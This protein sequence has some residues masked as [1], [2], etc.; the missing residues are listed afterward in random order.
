MPDVSVAI[1]GAGASGLSTAA[2]LKRRGIEAVALEQ[3]AE[4][5]LTWSRRYDRL[6][7]HTLRAYSGLAHYAIPRAASKY[8]SRDEYVDYLQSYARHFDLRIITNFAVQK[9]RA[10]SSSPGAWQVCG[11]QESWR[12]RVVVMATGQYRIP[13]IPAWP[14]LQD[15]RGDFSHAAKYKNPFPYV[16]KRVLVVGVGNTGA[17]IAADLVER[18]A[19]YVAISIRTPPTIVPR[20]P[21][22]NPVQRTSMLMS[23]L[24]TRIADR[25][26]KVTARIVLG[27]L[28][29]YGLPPAEWQ[30][31]TLGRVP[32][33]DVGFVG[34]LRRGLVTIRPAL[35]RLTAHEA[36]YADGRSEA[37]DAIIAA[38]GFTT[39]LDSLLEDTA[40]LND[41]REPKNAAG[42]PTASPGLFFI[43]FT[44]S[45][46]GHLFEANRASLKLARN[47]DQYMQRR[48]SIP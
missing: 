40:T 17:E 27:D 47:I 33:I 36:V 16:G 37:F 14:G 22:G 45:L 19:A 44:H 41:L 4:I 1:V 46:R 31:F 29:K 26:A 32:L 34:V 7:L 5:G 35:V 9:I 3:D 24:P 15:Y 28:T 48:W 18:G 6:R 20:D 21:F 11:T 43:G 25:I 2:A 30:P 8:P 42:E 38:T 10:D 39:G 13:R 12:A 23:L